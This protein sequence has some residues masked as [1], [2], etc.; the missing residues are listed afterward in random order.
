MTHHYIISIP[1]VIHGTNIHDCDFVRC[2]TLI[3]PNI[4]I[5]DDFFT[6]DTNYNTWTSPKRDLRVL[7]SCYGPETPSR[8]DPPRAEQHIP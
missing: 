8:R 1:V 3:V 4:I 2:I 6:D 5:T 7:E